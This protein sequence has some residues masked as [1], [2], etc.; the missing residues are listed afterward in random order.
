MTL[1]SFS[2]R[3]PLVRCQRKSQKLASPSPFGDDAVW[4]R[5]V[6]AVRPPPVGWE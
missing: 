1:L 6:L 5:S 2:S 3:S 4:L